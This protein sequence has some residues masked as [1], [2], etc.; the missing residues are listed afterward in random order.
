MMVV[1]KQLPVHNSGPRLV[2]DDAVKCSLNEDHR[3]FVLSK[4]LDL[5]QYIQDIT[6]DVFMLSVNEILKKVP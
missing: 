4:V 3:G 2:L 5:T 6:H 1:C